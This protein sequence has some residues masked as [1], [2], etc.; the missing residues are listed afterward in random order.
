MLHLK[1][2]TTFSSLPRKHDTKYDKSEEYMIKWELVI[3]QTSLKHRIKRERGGNGE[4]P[5]I[6]SG[7]GPTQPVLSGTDRL[8]HQPMARACQ[9]L[10]REAV[11]VRL[12]A[13]LVTH[14]ILLVTVSFR[15]VQSPRRLTI[16][17][18]NLPRTCPKRGT[19]Q[20]PT[21]HSTPTNYPHNLLILF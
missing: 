11:T 13:P 20:H 3:A 5:S 10:Q 8:A 12:C 18:V 19:P 17:M 6:N 16:W 9:F 4:R 15:L 21:P 14:V 7:K 1:T 2:S